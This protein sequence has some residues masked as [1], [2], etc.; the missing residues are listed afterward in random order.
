MPSAGLR[1]CVVAKS[2]VIH[3]DNSARD[4]VWRFLREQ[5]ID[6]SGHM[7]WLDNFVKMFNG[8]SARHRMPHLHR[9]DIT[10]HLWDAGYRL[11][12]SREG[13]AMI[14]GLSTPGRVARMRNS[15]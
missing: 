5:T 8:W 10:P 13:Q 11:V 14:A 3:T 12:V 4:Q 9:S 1:A 6:D 15:A 2:P 7:L